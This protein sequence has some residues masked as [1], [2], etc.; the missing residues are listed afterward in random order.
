MDAKLCTVTLRRTQDAGSPWPLGPPK[1]V[2]FTRAVK[3]KVLR[4]IRVSRSFVSE[5]ASPPSPGPPDG[6]FTCEGMKAVAVGLMILWSS[7]SSLAGNLRGVV[8][9]D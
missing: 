4:F 3:L 1:A 9:D 7:A 2:P 8:V 6:T 5:V